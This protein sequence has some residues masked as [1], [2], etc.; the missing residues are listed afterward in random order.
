MF[1]NECTFRDVKWVCCHASRT[2]VPMMST[3][4]F[5]PATFFFERMD[6]CMRIVIIYSYSA[7]AILLVSAKN[8]VY[9]YVV[10]RW[11][12]MLAFSQ[13]FIGEKS[14]IFQVMTFIYTT[15]RDCQ[16]TNILEKCFPNISYEVQM[17]CP[18]TIISEKYPIFFALPYSYI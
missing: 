2:Y 4:T 15:A 8:Y 12:C 13:K 1:I 14:E 11:G 10:P 6:P 9:V 3:E 16:C 5:A 17:R 7:S 18:T